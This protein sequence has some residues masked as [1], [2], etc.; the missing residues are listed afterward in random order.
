MS[1]EDF[2]FF[3]I[4]FYLVIMIC[5]GALLA[6][7]LKNSALIGFIIFD[8][9]VLVIAIIGLITMIHEYLEVRNE[10]TLA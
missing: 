9:V 2:Y 7:D 6:I 8:I 4:K 1:D 5:F 3:H 10:K